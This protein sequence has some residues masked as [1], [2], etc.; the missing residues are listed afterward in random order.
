M[1]GITVNDLKNA[2]LYSKLEPYLK[3]MDVETAIKR[4]R[5]NG[6][7][8]S[9]D[10]KKMTALNGNKA[11]GE[12]DAFQKE[13]K[14]DLNYAFKEGF[15]KAN[16]RAVARD[17][18]R[19]PAKY[20]PRR[21]D[22]PDGSYVVY[23]KSRK[24][25]KE[26]VTYYN[27]IGQQISEYD[28]KRI[29]NVKDM[30]IDSRTGQLAVTY[31]SQRENKI[32]NVLEL[33]AIGTARTLGIIYAC[34]EDK[35]EYRPT[36]NYNVNL[37][38]TIKTDVSDLKQ[39]IE[40][41]RNDFKTYIGQFE[42]WLK[43][44]NDIL[45]E[46]N[47]NTNMTAE[48]LGELNEQIKHIEE[49]LATIIINQEQNAKTAQEYYDLILDAIGNNSDLLG[50][51]IEK[52]TEN[53]TTLNDI[54]TLMKENNADQKEILEAVTKIKYGVD[55]IGLD[56]KDIKNV[57]TQISTALKNLPKA[58]EKQFKKY[59]KQIIS[60]IADGNTKLD[61]LIKLLQE[62]NQNIITGNEQQQ[63]ATEKV[64]EAIATMNGNMTKGLSAIL[65]A[66]RKGNANVLAKL[67]KLIENQEKL[68]DQFKDYDERT[69]KVLGDILAAITKLTE[70]VDKLDLDGLSGY[71]KSILEAIQNQP[72]YEKVLNLI[73]GKLGTLEEGQKTANT[74]IA[75][76]V[77]LVG[78][79]A[80]KFKDFDPSKLMKKL[81]EILKAIQDHEVKVD[82]TV[83]GKIKIILC[84]ENG[85]VV[86]EGEIDPEDPDGFHWIAG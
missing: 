16:E 43:N 31:Q 53:N 46:I 24:N 45:T 62:V 68:S 64:L 60:G 76:L 34:E 83:S 36:N 20:L 74:N 80:D 42:V 32:P 37:T 79:L 38:V 11:W 50:T 40:N 59:F 44:L 72:N 49:Q 7:W 17:V 58:L 27:K 2:G 78:L 75:E 15:S 82:V 85:N 54:K 9:A 73:L 30:K 77:K 4:A 22:L 48:R 86:H 52:L 41:L 10:D 6:E 1:S 19:N 70:A 12:F 23:Q 55:Q 29:T 25:G 69:Q 65:K 61:D 13:Q 35:I 71:M 81:D 5:E 57:V 84:D 18:G 67:D 47:T 39:T 26:T 56:V 8:T 21:C 51:V 63:K 66:I 33:L 28:F 3:T 14:D